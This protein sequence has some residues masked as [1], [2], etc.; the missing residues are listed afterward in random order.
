MQLAL[1]VFESPEAFAKRNS[2]ETDPSLVLGGP[3]TSRW[4]RPVFT[5]AAIHGLSL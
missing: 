3:T 2:A 4:W 5:L 1:L